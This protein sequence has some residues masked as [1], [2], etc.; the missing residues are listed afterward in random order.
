[1]NM[2]PVSPTQTSLGP[3]RG[4]VI[5]RILC[6]PDV[7]KLAQPEMDPSSTGA[8]WEPDPLKKLDIP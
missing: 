6:E 8:F 7:M 2:A 5:Q 1:M 3:S 4:G